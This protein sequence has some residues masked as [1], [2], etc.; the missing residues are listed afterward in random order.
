MFVTNPSLNFKVYAINVAIDLA[1]SRKDWYKSTSQPYYRPWIILMTDGEPDNDQDVNALAERI[2]QDT[3]KKRYVFLPI[4]VE[5]AN[6]S[7]LDKI[8]GNIS[9]MKLQGTKFSSFFKWL[10][11]SMGTVVTADEGKQVDL[12]EG[13]DDW[14]AA[15]T[16]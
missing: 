5:G 15:F 7:I 13:A 4:G 12:T 14:M 8:K 16:I 9:P 11:N 3:D 1:Q 10:S 6:M 2:K